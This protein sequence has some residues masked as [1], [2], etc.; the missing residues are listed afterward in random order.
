VIG[1]VILE[2]LC[3]EKEFYKEG[4]IFDV[5]VGFF[6]LSVSFLPFFVDGLMG[7]INV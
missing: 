4:N 5:N 6:L 2:G 3:I 7:L 1:R